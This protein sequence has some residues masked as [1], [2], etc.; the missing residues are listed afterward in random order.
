[1]AHSA[2]N[3]HK[4]AA[5]STASPSER[6]SALPRNLYDWFIILVIGSAVCGTV[7]VSIISHIVVAGLICL[8][9][10]IKEIADCHN[11]GKISW[12]SLWAIVLVIYAAVSMLWCPVRSL[13]AIGLWQL[14]WTSSILMGLSYAARRAARP[15]QS[16]AYG[17]LLLILLTLPIALWELTTDSHIPGFGDFNENAQTTSE[18]GEKQNLSF[19]AVTYKNYN[20][21]CTLI[22]MAMPILMYGLFALRKKWLF[23]V[24]IIST[25]LIAVI[26]SSRGTLLAVGIDLIVFVCYYRR[27]QIRR[28]VLTTWCLIIGFLFFV[29]KF[30]FALASQAI[31]RI[32]LSDKLNTASNTGRQDVWALGWDLFTDTYGLGT[33]VGSMESAYETTG[34]W[35]HYCHNMP[36]EMLMQYG[37]VMAVFLFAL[38]FRSFFGFC[39][40]TDYSYRMM[41][42]MFL[43]SFVP[44]AIVDDT[45]FVHPYVWM[46][47]A[48]IFCFFDFMP[49]RE[50]RS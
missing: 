8:P 18:E 39:R 6:P 47:L 14:F 4:T 15:T 42:R 31:F 37:V 5:P 20:S 27:L 43:L 29:V 36:L 19:A 38:V 21:Y 10:A 33:G 9:F 16:V 30:G 17:W 32:F 1:M 44:L 35:L 22:A 13:S 48:A 40:H 23:A 45:Y 26:N 2:H 12:G 46:W 3:P 24:A 25:T 7:Q 34:Y 50:K 41:G 28:K 11:S 49:P